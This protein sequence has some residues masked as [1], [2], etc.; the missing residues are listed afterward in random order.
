VITAILYT[1]GETATSGVRRFRA[2]WPATVGMTPSCRGQAIRA[3]ALGVTVTALVQSVAAGIGLA[4]VG[5]RYAAVLTVIIF[6]LCIAQLGPLL[7]LAP[8]V[9]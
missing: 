3:V 1:T 8:V 4:V 9:G 5:I 2:G 7:V 6:I